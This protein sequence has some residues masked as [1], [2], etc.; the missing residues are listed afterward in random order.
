MLGTITS[1]DDSIEMINLLRLKIIA[2]Q[3]T[4]FIGKKCLFNR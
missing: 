1:I 4:H 3:N 2:I